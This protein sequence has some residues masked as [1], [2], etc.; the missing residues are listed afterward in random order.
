M[1]QAKKNQRD[2][3]QEMTDKIITALEQGVASWTC[4]WDRSGVFSLPTNH[5]SNRAYQGINIC[6]LGMAQAAKGFRF[7]RWLTYK[8]AAA[9][10]GQVRKG[11]KGTTVIFYKTWE[12]ETDEKDTDVDIVVEHIPVLRTFTVF[13]LDQ[14]NGIELPELPALTGGFDPLD[15]A[16]TVLNASG[17]TIHERGM[18]AFYRPSSD[19]ITLPDRKRFTKADDFYATALHELTHSTKHQSRCDRQPYETT[20]PGGAYAFEELVAELGSAF[21]MAWLGLQGTVQDH[22]NYIESWLTLLKSDKKALFRAAAQ[23]QKAHQWIKNVAEPHA[24]FAA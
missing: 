8:Q 5:S 15:A 11:E 21:S 4:P 24:V 17:V 16:E 14:I 9:L 3:Y 19:E 23:A 1:T 22:A 2:L 13:N 6:L 20:I 18:R 10:G 7:S 12:H